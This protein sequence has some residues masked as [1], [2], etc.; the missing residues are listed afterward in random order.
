MISVELLMGCERV[1]SKFTFAFLG[2]FASL[3]GPVP[4]QAAT[5]AKALSP[6]RTR[7]E[8]AKLGHDYVSGITFP[9]FHCM[10]Y[11]G[12]NSYFIRSR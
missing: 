6:L 12:R 4:L 10:L 8:K 7:K 11:S 9:S 1:V 3:R 5:H 2:D